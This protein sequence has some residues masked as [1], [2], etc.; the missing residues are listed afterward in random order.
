MAS[1]P[2]VATAVHERLQ[3]AAI[4]FG[5]TYSGYA[6]SFRGEF[7]ENPLKIFTNNWTTGS[8]SA[9]SLKTSSCILFDPDQNFNSFGFEAEDTYAKLAEDEEHYKWY[10]FK[11]FK[12]LL[13]ENKVSLARL[14]ANILL[15]FN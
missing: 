13:Y 15:A 4:D 12:M 10:Y 11:R 1:L 7:L 8:S 6:M 2:V 3:V 5:T 9:V 14:D